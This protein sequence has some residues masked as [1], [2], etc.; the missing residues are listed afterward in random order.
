MTI[1]LP[2]TSTRQRTEGAPHDFPRAGDQGG[3]LWGLRLL[4][5]DE[6]TGVAPAFAAVDECS[7]QNTG[8]ITSTM[9]VKITVSGAPV[10]TKS[11]DTIAMSGPVFDISREES[12][13]NRRDSQLSRRSGSVPA[14]VEGSS[15]Q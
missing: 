14:L 5:V 4:L 7:G 1:L 10:F 13:L 2:M 3:E 6:A 12:P 8:N 11:P 15:I 9:A